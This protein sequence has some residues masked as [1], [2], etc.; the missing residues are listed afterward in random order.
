M[1]LAPEKTLHQKAVGPHQGSGV[2]RQKEGTVGGERSQQ[3]GQEAEE[4]RAEPVGPWG[5]EEADG[6]ATDGTQG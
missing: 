1:S 6:P 4:A 3:T 2:G 5:G